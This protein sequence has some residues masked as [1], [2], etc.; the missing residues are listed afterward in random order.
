MLQTTYQLALKLAVILLLEKLHTFLLI[1]LSGFHHL[2][3][4][5]QNI[6]SNGQGRSFTASTFFQ[7]AVSLSQVGARPSH[8]HAPLAPAPP[9]H[10][11]CLSYTSHS[12]ASRRFP[13]VLDR[14]PPKNSGATHLGSAGDPFR[15]LPESTYKTCRLTLLIFSQR[16]I[17]SSKG[18]R[19]RSISSSRCSI[20]RS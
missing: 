6:V 18:C 17:C 14:H 2:T 1:A 3:V 16:V 11:G 5:D 19:W 20:P 9:A 8:P 12:A 7:T 4:D 10:T 15:P 13:C